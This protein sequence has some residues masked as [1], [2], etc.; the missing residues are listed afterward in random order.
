MLRKVFTIETPGVEGNKFMSNP[1]KYP[2]R[3]KFVKKK[4][5]K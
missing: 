5:R 1:R 3:F 4:L 2:Q